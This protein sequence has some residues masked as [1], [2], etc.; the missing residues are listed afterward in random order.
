M[1]V[2]VSPRGWRITL[3][4]GEVIDFESF[5]KTFNNFS[6]AKR[7]YL[8]YVWYVVATRCKGADPDAIVREI[9]TKLRP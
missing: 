8:M 1:S 6:T 5:L 2:R 3:P 7:E 9:E 4:S